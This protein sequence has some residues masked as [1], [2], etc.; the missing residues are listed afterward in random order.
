M[1]IFDA[2]TQ[3]FYWAIDLIEGYVPLIIHGMDG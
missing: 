2:F 1:W 3:A